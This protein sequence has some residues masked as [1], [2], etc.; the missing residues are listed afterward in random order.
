[1][2]LSEI[3][4]DKVL[5]HYTNAVTDTDDEIRGAGSMAYVRQSRSPHEH[6]T[7]QRISQGHDPHNTYAWYVKHHTD[8]HNPYL[9]IIR[10]V[11]PGDSGLVTTAM[12]RLIPF[13]SA[14]L[15]VPELISGQAGTWF[16]DSLA[17]K[18][19]RSVEA[20]SKDHSKCAKIV[21]Y[22]L[23]TAMNRPDL[24]SDP[25]LKEAIDIIHQVLSIDPDFRLDLTEDNIMWRITGTKPHLVITDPI[26]TMASYK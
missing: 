3:V 12:E 22:A 16:V 1:M 2:K 24:I 21:V 6:D 10:N 9:P 11:Q 5:R 20:A 19:R 14:Q 4:S 25:K 8:G 17:Q 18:L 23:G 26:N 13:T 15:A 7:V